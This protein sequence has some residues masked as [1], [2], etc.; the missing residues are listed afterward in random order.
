MYYTQIIKAHISNVLKPVLHERFEGVL[1]NHNGW[2]VFMTTHCLICVYMQSA[3]NRLY[4]TIS[5][6]YLDNSNMFLFV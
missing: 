3:L 2:R 4:Q 6:H 5:K 1:C